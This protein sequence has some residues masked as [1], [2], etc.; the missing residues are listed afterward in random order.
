LPG[1][2][3]AA[4]TVS[5]SALD[6]VKAYILN[7]KEHHRKRDFKDELLTLLRLHEVEYNERYV[8]D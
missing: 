5:K 8:F 2:G 3:Y 1:D 7:Q 4:F 6:D